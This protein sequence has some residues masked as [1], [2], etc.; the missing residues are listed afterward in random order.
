MYDI[1]ICVYITLCIYK[2]YPINIECGIEIVASLG[3]P[4]IEPENRYLEYS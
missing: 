1:Y 2:S 3:I 4:G